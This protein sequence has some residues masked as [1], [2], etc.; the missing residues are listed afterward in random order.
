MTKAAY[1]QSVGETLSAKLDAISL[2]IGL[3]P[4]IMPQMP[5]FLDQLSR[6]WEPEAPPYEDEAEE[7]EE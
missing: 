1:E 2:C 7:D 5:P 6:P 3:D 4:T